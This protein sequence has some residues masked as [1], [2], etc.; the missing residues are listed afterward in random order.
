MIMAATLIN[1]HTDKKRTDLQLLKTVRAF[2]KALF[3]S[4]S[5]INISLIKA[6]V[7]RFDKTEWTLC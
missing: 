3:A 6:R 7:I 5:V 4:T 2:K 1:K